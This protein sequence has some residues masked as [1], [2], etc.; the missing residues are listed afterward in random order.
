MECGPCITSSTNI[1]FDDQ[2]ES[3]LETHGLVVCYANTDDNLSFE[4]HLMPFAERVA[5]VVSFCCMHPSGHASCHVLPIFKRSFKLN[6]WQTLPNNFLLHRC[7][8]QLIL[9]SGCWK[10]ELRNS[11]ITSPAQI[12]FMLKN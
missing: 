10:N 4:N 7:Y 1:V 6:P 5:I 9:Q 8:F 12:D 2:N 3:Y 11:K